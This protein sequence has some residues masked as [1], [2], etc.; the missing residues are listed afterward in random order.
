MRKIMMFCFVCLIGVGAG[1]AQ[2]IDRQEKSKFVVMPTDLILVTVAQQ[3]ECPLRLEDVKYLAGTDGGGSPSFFIR[4]TGTKPI[5]SFIV[6]GPDWTMSW[7][8]RF[9]KRLLM[10]GE[11]AEGPD[12]AE[13]V[14]LSDELRDKMNLKGPMRS[15]L[16][17]MV[18]RVDFADGEVFSAESTY[19]ALQ[20]YTE[21]LGELAA[22]AKSK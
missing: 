9:T 5:R 10:P 18:I 4:N 20:T 22:K 8:E 14:T 21:R 19:K 3:P 13:I 7:S 11:R 16:V 6:G 12:N 15:V 2:K 17:L 1:N